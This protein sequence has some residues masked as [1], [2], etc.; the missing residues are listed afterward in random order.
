MAAKTF[1]LIGEEKVAARVRAI[2]LKVPAKAAAALFIEAN[3]E[4]TESRRRTPVDT[5][6]LR[7]STEVSK[8]D[9]EFGAAFSDIEVTI[10]VGGPAAPYAV[11]VHENLDAF[12][13]VGRSKYLESTIMESAPFMQRRIAKRLGVG[14]LK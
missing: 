1:S 14:G 8:P 12:H 10:S 3:I 7:A 4:A 11:A 2:A 5:G 13:K 9:V 6:A